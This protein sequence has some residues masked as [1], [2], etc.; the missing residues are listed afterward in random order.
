MNGE[1]AKY[2]LA[3]V[4]YGTIGMLLHYITLPS[5]V[6]VLCRGVIG[7]GTILMVMLA[8]RRP[9]RWRTI[10]PHLPILAVSGACLG[11]NWIFLF[12]AYRATTVAVASLCNYM[13]PVLVIAVS[14]AVFGERLTRRKAGCIL[15]AF[16]GIVLVSG[17][18]ESTG[19]VRL[20]GMALGL[21]AALCFVGIIL[22]NK[23]CTGIDPLEKTVCQL[24]VSACVV[25]PY[26]LWM[27]RGTA[28]TWGLRSIVLVLVLGVVHTGVAY[29]LYFGAMARIPVESVA[30]LGYLEPVV[31]V[32]TSAL[33]LREPITALGVLGAVLILGA[34]A[35]SELAP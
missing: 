21:L 34:A 3:V 23:K 28:L 5:E 12:A 2:I 6:V 22:C 17:V 26:V 8:R 33:I 9:P 7:T 18:L 31:S 30:L 13:A 1:K 19:E 25:L 15:A 10:R 32:V 27:E 16:A 29:I 14:P 20:G 11:L 24:A 35:Y 4:L